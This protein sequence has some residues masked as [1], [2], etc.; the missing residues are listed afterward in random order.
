MIRRLPLIV[1]A[2]VVV[3]ALAAG[4]YFLFFRPSGGSVTATPGGQFPAGDPFEGGEA[5]PVGDSQEAGEEVA[6]YLIKITDGPVAHGFSVRRFER[7]LTVEGASTSAR[8][9]TTATTEARYIERASGNVYAYNLGERTL[10]RLTNRTLPGIQEALWLAD[11]SMSVVRY[12]DEGEVFSYAL[13]A[14]E[15]EGYPLEGGLSQAFVS[16]SSTIVTLLSGTNGSI[17]TAARSDGTDA[18]TLFTSLLSSIRAYPAGTSF[19]I[20]TKA[21]AQTDGYAFAVRGSSSERLLG[22]F[23]GLTVLPSPSGAYILYSYLS[24][25]TAKAA[26]Y[27]TKTGTATAL[28]VMALPD[29]CVWSANETA[30]YC[31]VPRAL[32]TGWP[33]EWYQGAMRFTDRIWR[34][35]LDSRLASLI[36]DPKL[37][38]DADIDAVA[39]AIDPASDALVFTNRNDGSLWLYDL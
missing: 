14:G 15:G 20:A 35:D 6:P 8:A 1:I 31:G 19:V 39:L 25:N 38:A 30:L 18:R 27:D 3:I 26:L 28:P 16:G 22:P 7:Q 12:E 33:D 24:G 29:K 17:A 10:T 23:K 2:L 36:V 37:V 5:P 13:P 21:S 34:I 4:A 32:G 9:V 11:G